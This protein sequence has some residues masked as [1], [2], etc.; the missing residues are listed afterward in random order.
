[1]VQCLATTPPSLGVKGFEAVP[2]YIY[3]PDAS[4]QAYK[5]A[6]NWATYASKIYAVKY[7]VPANN[8]LIGS[9][10]P[11][12]TIGQTGAVSAEV[13]RAVTDYMPVNGGDSITWGSNMARDMLIEFD[14]N[15]V[16]VDHWS[17]TG[18]SRTITTNSRTRYVRTG[19]V[20]PAIAFSYV[21]N[22]TTGEYIFKGKEV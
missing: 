22:N 12:Q 3:V 13:T 14:E 5:D 16:K 8:I 20:I 1:M 19:F 6:S 11:Y 17:S 4:V 18:S 2:G 15:F 7:A 10:T 21:K 9:V